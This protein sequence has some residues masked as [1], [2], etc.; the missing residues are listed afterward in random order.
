M[1]VVGT[2]PELIK[3][4]PVVRHL[5]GLE[6][7]RVTIVST[8]QQADLMPA[9]HGLL[10]AGIDYQLGA[11]SAGQSINALLSRTLAALDPVI[12]EVLPALIVVQGDTTS[13]FAGALAGQMRAVPVAHIEAGL[14][15]GDPNSPFPEEMNRRLISQLASLHCAPTEQNRAALLAEGIAAERVLVTG[16][17]VVASL[18]GVLEEPSACPKLKGL[19][20]ALEG[21]K[22]IVLTT[23]RR[24]S[25]GATLDRNLQTLRT[26]VADNPGTALV[27][28]V[29]PNPKVKAAVEGI[30]SDGERVFLI[31]PLD[32]PAFLG[33][34][35][36]AWL[37]VSDS[38]GV[39]EEVASLGKPL[40]VLRA[41]TERPEAIEIGVAKMAGEW[42]G[43]LKE[44]LDDRDALGRWIDSVEVV[45]NPFGD[46]ESPARIA[47]A[48][49]D[50]LSKQVDRASL[51]P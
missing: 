20:K 30:L 32:Y 42:P 43:Q 46:L 48:F 16:N 11:M 5:K 27:V 40:L 15:T 26:F 34:L 18:H 38:G 1:F 2:R 25:F 50:F 39:Q 47:A 10:D 37:I 36:A 8:T 21:L 7:I 6:G 28:P 13:A 3:V 33:L 22:P 19:L 4:A 35:Q 45:A 41:K 29:H 14:R 9:F 23:H 49:A 24:E 12:A 44:L 17:P 51:V 31:E